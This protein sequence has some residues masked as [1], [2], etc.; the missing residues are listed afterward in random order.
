MYNSLCNT[1]HYQNKQDRT[2][3]DKETNVWLAARVASKYYGARK[4]LIWRNEGFIEMHPDA[5]TKSAG[6]SYQII[7][8][9]VLRLNKRLLHS[10]VVGTVKLLQINLMNQLQSQ[11]Y[12]WPCINISVDHIRAAEIS[13]NCV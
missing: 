7:L 11:L 8:S 2:F 5:V 4:Q 12:N 10:C 1:Q 6:R 3:K 9:S 13:L